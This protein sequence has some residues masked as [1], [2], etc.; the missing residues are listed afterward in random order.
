MRVTVNREKI[1][2]CLNLTRWQLVSIAV[3]VVTLEFFLSLWTLRTESTPDS[4]VFVDYW[5]FPFEAI[6]VTKAVSTGIYPDVGQ[7]LHITQ[8]FEYLWGGMIMNLI[9]Y[10]VFSVIVV[11][12]ATWIRDEIE[13][14]RYYKS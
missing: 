8:T 12:L 5:G 11:K 13:Y 10:V 4:S 6:K 2:N 9:V 1:S 3:L 14:R 7:V